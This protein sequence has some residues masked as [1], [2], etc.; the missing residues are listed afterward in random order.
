MRKGPIIAA[1]CIAV[2]SL[3]VGTTV[4]SSTM[5]YQWS[6]IKGQKDSRPSEPQPVAAASSQSTEQGAKEGG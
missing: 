1:L 2:A 4:F 6:S 5:R 3:L